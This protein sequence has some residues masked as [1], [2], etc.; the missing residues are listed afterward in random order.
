[1]GEDYF[2]DKRKRVGNNA[3]NGTV[4]TPSVVAH[5]TYMVLDAKL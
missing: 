4:V 2:D 5:I 3:T 1:M